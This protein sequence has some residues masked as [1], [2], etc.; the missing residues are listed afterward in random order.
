MSASYGFSLLFCCYLL[1]DRYEKLDTQTKTALTK[2][3]NSISHTSSTLVQPIGVK[4][5]RK[6]SSSAA[7]DEADLI[8]EEGEVRLCY[9]RF[10]CLFYCDFLISL[11]FR[12]F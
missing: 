4:K 2:Y 8:D 9:D 10:H 11:C 3:Y 12:L 1:L 6:P 5:A 7:V